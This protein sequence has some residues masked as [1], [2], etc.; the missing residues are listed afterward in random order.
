[1]FCK[2][3]GNEIEE[4]VRFCS[5]CGYNFQIETTTNKIINTDK[6]NKLNAALVLNIVSLVIALTVIFGIPF[7]T[8]LVYPMA[9][10]NSDM[11]MLCSS[12][13]IMAI[14]TSVVGV[15]VKYALSKRM[16]NIKCAYIYL[17]IA[18]ITTILTLVGSFFLFPLMV[19]LIGL[20]YYVPSTLQIIAAVKFFQATK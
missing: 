13:M 17:I 16:S 2:N 20:I 6:E 1:M 19:C 5:H 4:N 10:D 15:F 14:I 3:C 9:G 18:L 7:F 8:D 11:A 12:A